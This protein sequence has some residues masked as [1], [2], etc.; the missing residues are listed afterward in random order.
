MTTKRAGT[1]GAKLGGMILAAL[2]ATG[3]VGAGEPMLHF[4]V[5]EPFEIT[6]HVFTSG[7]ITME[8]LRAFTPTTTLVEVWVDGA[9]LGVISARTVAAET[10]AVRDEAIFRREASGRLVMV[11][12]RAV[13][14]GDGGTYRFLD[15]AGPGTAG[16]R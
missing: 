15:G 4:D 1:V 3:R 9:C 7:S 12:Y 16:T 14:P 8:R 11:G 5:R 2:F 10:P 6:G 13:G